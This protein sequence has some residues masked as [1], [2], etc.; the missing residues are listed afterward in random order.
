MKR[1][2]IRTSGDRNAWREVEGDF[3]DV[4]PNPD[5]S[6]SFHV[7]RTAHNDTVIAKL[8]IWD[9]AWNYYTR[10]T[11]RIFKKYVRPKNNREAVMSFLRGD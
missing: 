2:E 9:S 6:L 10:G 5:D 7:P 4:V 1:L 3:I 8:K 11:L